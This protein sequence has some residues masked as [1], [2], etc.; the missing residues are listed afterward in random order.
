MAFCTQCGKEIKD[1]SAFCPYC[2]ST[3]VSPVKT[4]PV[5]SEQPA[6]HAEGARTGQKPAASSGPAKAFCTQCGRELKAGSPYCPYCGA[7]L[8]APV[9]N[10]AGGVKDTGKKTKPVKEKKAKPVKEKPVK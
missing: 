6:D 3:V 5:S 1:G 4:E 7:K 2:G 9:E 8:A 10:A